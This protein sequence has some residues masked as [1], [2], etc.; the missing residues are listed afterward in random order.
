MV[1]N[2]FSSASLFRF[3]SLRGQHPLTSTVSMQQ[4][5]TQ[6]Q[7]LIADNAYTQK[8]KVLYK[9]IVCDWFCR[10]PISIACCHKAC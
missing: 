10:K 5:I 8:H 2:W 7:L 3:S 4:L 1:G 6:Q 9:V